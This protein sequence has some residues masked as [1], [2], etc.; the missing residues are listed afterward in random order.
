M[1]IFRGINTEYFDPKAVKQSEELKLISDWEIQK[2]KKL[3]LLPGRLTSWKGQEMFIESL[4]LAN[5]FFRFSF[6]V[7]P[8]FFIFV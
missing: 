6:G 8:I 5:A 7:N 2:D 3:I 4:N 1:V